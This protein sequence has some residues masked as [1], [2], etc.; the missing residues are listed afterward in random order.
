[1][2][3]FSLYAHRML[4]PML[5]SLCLSKERS[6]K[7]PSLHVSI[8]CCFQSSSSVYV[9]KRTLL[10]MPLFSF[11]SFRENTLSFLQLHLL[12][13]FL[14]LAFS[15]HSSLVALAV[16][17][18]TTLVWDTKVRCLSSQFETPHLKMCSVSSQFFETPHLRCV[19]FLTS[20]RHHN[21]AVFNFSPVRWSRFQVLNNQSMKVST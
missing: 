18:L 9:P 13:Y 10:P 8:E 11:Y 7:C 12:F 15:G 20:L 16:T 5:P 3:L 2:P 21:S 17:V 19:Q 6:F 14:S 1:M 4:F